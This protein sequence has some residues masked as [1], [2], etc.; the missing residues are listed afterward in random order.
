MANER[1]TEN[2]VRKHF[3]KFEKE[4]LI[5]EQKSEN[6]KINK[7]LKNASKKGEGAGYPEFIISFSDNQNFIIVIECKS[8]VKKHESKNRDKYSEYAVDGAL[9]YASYL[10]KEFDVLA[11]AVSGQSFGELKVSHFL[12]L[13]GENNAVPKFSN[14]LLDLDS[15]IQ[16]YV[17]SPEKF[18]QDYDSLL[19]FSKELNEELH[20]KKVKESQRSLLISGILIALENSAFE[21][22]YKK[23]SKPEDL[24]NNLADT[25]SNEL[26]NANLHGKKL[27]S[28]KTAFT[29]IRTHTAL[30]GEKNVLS[31]IIDN[32]DTHIN[33]FIKTYKYFDVLG[34]FYIEFLRYANNDKGLGI[35]LT[36]HHI[37]H[38]F[39]ELAD[40]NKDSV[41]LDNCCGTGGFLISAMSKMIK[42]AKDDKR[43]VESIKNKQLIGIEWQDDI[44][45]LACSNMFIHQDGK[46]NI[47][48]GSCFDGKVI[49]QVKEFRPNT[50]FLNP[51]YPNI[52]TDPLELEFVLN[53]LEILQPNSPCVAII[54]I[55]CV[56]ASKGK[57]YELKRR[58]LESHTL[59]AA[60]SMPNQLFYNNDVGVVTSVLVITAHKP[61]PRGKKTWFGYFKNDG[62]TVQKHKG[63][64]DFGREWD[65]IEKQWVDIFKNRKVIKGLSL[66]KEVAPEDEWCAEAYMKTKYSELMEQ[67]F[68]KELKKYA[69]FTIITSD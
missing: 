30:S 5:E 12:H 8:S 35:V 59:E 17:K 45:A 49:Q 33:H 61:H 42:D 40:V 31:N 25:I 64:G 34:Q 36:P 28:L 63:R 37:T 6:P 29:F 66:L 18:R 3:T 14:K 27:E 60:M 9:L 53:N 55:S 21:I 48:H 39:A 57:E 20:S 67:N 22:S 11:I 38:L 51:P 26:K 58:I 13:K 2:I 44:F 69:A 65:A 54:P 43:K 15:Y 47:I 24:A 23:H 62:Y 1:K 19:D 68:I 4:C 16:G 50:G 10:S 7:L 56:L 52:D 41:I 46:T 32:I